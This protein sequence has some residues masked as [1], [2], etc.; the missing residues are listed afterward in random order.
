MVPIAKA[1]SR[2]SQTFFDCASHVSEAWFECPRTLVFGG[3]MGG[4]HENSAHNGRRSMMC[5]GIALPGA[6]VAQT[7]KEHVNLGPSFE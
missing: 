1:Y 6:V 2:V 3:R 4:Y 7:A 5:L